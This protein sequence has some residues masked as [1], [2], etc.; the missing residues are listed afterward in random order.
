MGRYREEDGIY[1]EAEASIC[2]TCE[3]KQCRGFCERLKE[4][5]KRLHKKKQPTQHKE[6]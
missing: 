6:D 2:L 3:S 5:K 1:G 4:E